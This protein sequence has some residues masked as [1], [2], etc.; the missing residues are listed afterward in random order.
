[1]EIDTVNY[2]KLLEFISQAKKNLSYEFEARFMDQ[3][4]KYNYRR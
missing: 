2:N 3:K 1:M 4:K